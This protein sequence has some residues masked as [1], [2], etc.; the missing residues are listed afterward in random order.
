MD[1]KT[2]GDS[3]G[4]VLFGKTRRAV[5]SR[6]YGHV[7][8]AFYL[9]QLVRDTGAGLGAVQREV[10]LLHGAGIICRE[11]RGNQVYYQAN[12]RCPVFEELRSLVVKTAGIGDVLRSALRPLSDRIRLAFLFGSVARGDARRGSDVDVLIVGNVTFAEV[13]SALGPSQAV[14]GREI[15]PSVYPVEEFRAKL[16]AKHHF[17]DTVAREP[18]VFLIG[19]ERE[20]EG[21][22]E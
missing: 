12:S 14:L 20:L 15:N 18:K 21:L 17:V 22:A 3:L 19:D 6:L 2:E 16:A 4:G 10:G 7:D 11:R 5:L 8:E 13:V 1:T 9:R